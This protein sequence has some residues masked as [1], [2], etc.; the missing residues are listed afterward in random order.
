[1][2]SYL[3]I[4][5]SAISLIFNSCNISG[6]ANTTPTLS[7]YASHYNQKDTLNFYTTD[8][9]NVYRLDTTFVGDTLLMSGVLNGFTNYLTSYF[10]IPGDTSTLKILL[11]PADSLNVYFNPTMSD[12]ING[13]YIFQ[14]K[15]SW[16]YFPLKVLPLKPGNTAYIQFALTSDAV[17]DSGIGGNSVG[18]KIMMPFKTRPATVAPKHR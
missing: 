13:K 4:F 17:F 11:P 15:Q 3:F 14:S 10:A 18:Y 7:L 1:M 5:L 12:Y 2:K 8:Q 6:T 16:F 9:A